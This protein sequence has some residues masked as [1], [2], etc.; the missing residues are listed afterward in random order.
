[1]RPDIEVIPTDTEID[2]RIDSQLQ[3]AI[4]E[5]QAQIR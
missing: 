1:V 3:R 5:L 4:Q 2:Q